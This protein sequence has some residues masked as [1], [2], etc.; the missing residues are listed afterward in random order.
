MVVDVSVYNKKCGAIRRSS[1]T[2][3]LCLEKTLPRQRTL[4]QWCAGT[5]QRIALRMTMSMR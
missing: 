4:E 5:P 1:R 3:V 2:R